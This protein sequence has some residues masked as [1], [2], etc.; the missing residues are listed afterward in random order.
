LP[1]SIE[2][3]AALGE[4]LAKCSSCYLEELTSLSPGKAF[5]KEV[6]SVFI[7]PGLQGP[8]SEV[9]KPL[10]RQ[11]MFPTFCIMLSHTS[12]SF[13]ETARLLVK[14]SHIHAL[15]NARSVL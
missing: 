7:I 8:P 6:P 3:L 14:V 5:V 2:E 10:A 15:G 11:I 4:D 9:L 12:S 1:A 13:S